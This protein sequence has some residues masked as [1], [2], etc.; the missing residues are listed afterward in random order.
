MFSRSKYILEQMFTGKTVY[1]INVKLVESQT[2]SDMHVH[3]HKWKHTYVKTCTHRYISTY[4]VV[5]NTVCHHSS[6]FL[7]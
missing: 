1:N 5:V 2:Q 4:T 6:S 3:I 7:K